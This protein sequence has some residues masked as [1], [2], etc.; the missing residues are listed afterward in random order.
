[1]R[2]ISALLAQENLDAMAFQE[3]WTEASLHALIQG[4]E[5]A[6]HTHVWHTGVT[7]GGSGLLVVSKWP[8][9][10]AAFEPFVSRGHPERLLHLDYYSGKGVAQL[11]LDT[12]AGPVVLLNTHL[13]ANY[14]MPGAHDEYVGVRAA[15]VIQLSAALENVDLPVMAIGD[16]NIQES[17]LNY[18]VLLGLAGL[19]DVAVELDNRQ[20][21]AL[22]NTPYRQRRH[23]EKRIDYVF[24]RNGERRG[25]RPISIERRFDAPLDFGGEPGTFSD[26]AGLVAE[27]ELRGSAQAMHTPKA[28]AIAAAAGLITQ[29]REISRKR[30]QRSRITATGALVAGF[31]T[32]AGSRFAARSRRRFLE[33]SLKVAAGLSFVTLAGQLGLSEFTND[34]EHAGYDHAERLLARLKTDLRSPLP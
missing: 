22:A 2:E 12:N 23:G 15:Q 25:L 4:A 8:I 17:E 28:D 1:M 10:D 26:H 6:G 20:S 9:V 5:R 7:T 32:L 13:Q 18:R 33:N 27:F 3:V 31:A 34:E 30:K 29:G 11:T 19:R 16:F 21:T 24:Y 14:T